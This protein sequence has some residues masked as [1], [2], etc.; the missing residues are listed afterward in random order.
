MVLKRVLVAI[1][2][3]ENAMKTQ[4]VKKGVEIL[5]IIRMLNHMNYLGIFILIL[6]TFCSSRLSAETVSL[7]SGLR[8]KYEF[9]NNTLDT[10]GNNLNGT[11]NGNPGYTYD[12]KSN[13]NRAI[14]LNGSAQFVRFPDSVFGPSVNAFS[15]Y[16]RVLVDPTISGG[17][18]MKG[19][20]NGEA[21]LKIV[22]GDFT[23]QV[24][25]SN[26]FYA[27]G[28]ATSGW[29]NLA[30]IYLKDSYIALYVDGV[31]QQQTSIS[32]SDMH[33][34]SGFYSSVGAYVHA[35]GSFEYLTGSVD[36]VRIYDRLLNSGEI[37]ALGVPE[38]SAFS[39]LAVG[40]GGLALMRRR[41]S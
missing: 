17:I 19:S 40:F 33:A 29:H 1:G 36:E 34:S 5:G 32:I 8:L 3:F 14:F 27:R 11:P 21:Q 37:Q 23:F 20:E 12:G 25:T 7:D 4:C 10:S 26:W 18:I 39:L 41:R 13:A 38:P 30:G 28:L 22:D 6:L 2:R 24:N 35:G 15:F 31:L 16:S 9:N